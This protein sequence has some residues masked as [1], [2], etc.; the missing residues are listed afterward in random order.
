MQ[1]HIGLTLAYLCYILSAES[2]LFEDVHRNRVEV[3]AEFLNLTAVC[4]LFQFTR[5]D[6]YTA[7]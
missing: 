1:V 6:E 7:A 4:I 2:N 5:G 3:I